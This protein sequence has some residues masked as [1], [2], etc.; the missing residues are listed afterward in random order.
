M[1]ARRVHREARFFSG[2]AHFA[3]SEHL[4]HSGLEIVPALLLLKVGHNLAKEIT[5]LY[6]VFVLFIIFAFHLH[7]IEILDK[8]VQQHFKLIIG[9]NYIGLCCLV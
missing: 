8:I 7:R 5:I 6:F 2:L 1:Q 9:L 4:L 3:A